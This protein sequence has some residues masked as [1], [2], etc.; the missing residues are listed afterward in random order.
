MN[1]FRKI[2]L[3]LLAAGTFGLC[4]P[5][6]LQAGLE[7]DLLPG[8]DLLDQWRIDEAERYTFSL[9]RKYK[10]SG[11][12]FFLLARIEFYKG[13]YE[14]AE[15]ILK[16]VADDQE[17]VKE[18]K[19]LVEKTRRAAADFIFEESEHFR[20]AYIDGQDRLLVHYAREVL[21]KSY[22]VLGKILG[23]FPAEK[24]LVEFYP[25]HVPFS[26]ISPLTYKD[27]ITSGTVALCKYRRIM[28]ISPGA[29]FRGYN[30]MDT[31]SHEYVH[32]L[33]SEKSRN[34]V[35]LW[36][37]EGIAKYLESRWRG[38]EKH[39]DPLM[40][41]ALAGGL[42]EDYMISLEEMMPSLAKLKNAEDVQLAYAEVATMVEYMVF[43]KGEN[44]LAAMVEDF[45]EETPLETIL[46]KRL[47]K[48]LDGF[49]ADWKKFVKGKNLT[50]IPGLKS[51]QFRFKN[52]RSKSNGREEDDYKEVAD[53]RARDLTL[54]GDIFKTRNYLQAAAI[55]YEK[56]IQASKTIS[57]ILYNKLAGTYLLRKEYAKAETL[58]K[59][60]LRYYPSFSSTLVNLGELY[61]LK[62]DM[63]N[64]RQSL[65]QAVRLNPFNPFV[66]SRLT[67][68]YH[69]LKRDEEKEIQARL[70]SYLE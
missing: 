5:G 62:G 25:G 57:P 68:V 42:A 39:L 19:S 13:N 55:E 23:H 27:I 11:D 69:K 15:K 33:L 4:G 30:W 1:P 48:T 24:T 21:E 64:A 41:T 59:K 14:K 9:M 31:L 67:E 32:Y 52:S 6:S 54:L 47:G 10:N 20:F 8:Y 7:E 40:E 28:I 36:L 70:F 29:L 34:N 63:E 43:L 35:P 66:H 49:Q 38:D 16:E 17:V 46:E 50:V 56:A 2:F 58:L 65:E 51:V 37:H 12:V 53:S 3:I 26:Q 61:F 45:A 18:F 44:I 22:D 60:N